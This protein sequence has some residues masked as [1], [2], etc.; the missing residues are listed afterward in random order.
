M[1]VG[2]KKAIEILFTEY[3]KLKSANGHP[4]DLK[5]IREGIEYL[6]YPFREDLTKDI[7]S[8]L[9]DPDDD[10]LNLVKADRSTPEQEKA[11]WQNMAELS[12]KNIEV[13][14]YA[15]ETLKKI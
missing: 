2:Y 6:C 9:Q 11:F 14:L 3:E 1:K 13:T 5:S 10:S 7:R 15:L 4:D 8:P 12:K